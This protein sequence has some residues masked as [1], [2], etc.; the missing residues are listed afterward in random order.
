M[1]KKEKE[2]VVAKGKEEAEAKKKL[3]AEEAK[4][5]AEESE[6]ESEPLEEE[7]SEEESAD[8]EEIDYEEVARLENERAEKETDARKKAEDALAK[9]RFDDSEAKR[10]AGEMKESD[11]ED[12]P[13][14][15]KDLNRI[16]LEDRQSY[17]KEINDSRALEIAKANTTSDAEAKAAH[18]IWK[19][20]VVPTGN[21]EEDVL[22]AIGGLNRNKYLAKNKEIMRTLKSKSTV[23]K[24]ATGTHKMG[25]QA[26]EAKVSSNDA[27]AM[28]AA[29]MVWDGTKRVYKRPIN[30]GMFYY[31]DPKTKKQWKGK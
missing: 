8:E 25:E 22:F 28:K 7:E 27:T 1:T 6:E 9:K 10:K 11:E 23:S 21:L 30:K 13:L 24:D 14:T 5:K 18:L 17:Q 15:L 31:F 2:A 29:G 26:P 20:R 16:R 12:K 4:K 19:H 3:E